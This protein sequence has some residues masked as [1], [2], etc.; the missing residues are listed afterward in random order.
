LR[1]LREE[2]EAGWILLE[3]LDDHRVQFK[4][5]MALRYTD[6]P[7]FLVNDPT[8]ATMVLHGSP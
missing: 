4:R 3:K 1:H 2:A 6:T 5:P 8:A 7:E